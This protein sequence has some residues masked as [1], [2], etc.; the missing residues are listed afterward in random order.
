MKFTVQQKD[1]NRLLQVAGNGVPRKTTLPIL[2]NFLIEA[3]PGGIRVAATDLEISISTT[4]ET[5]VETPGTVAVN[6]RRLEEVVRELP[7]DAVE[8]SLEDGKFQMQCQR[9]R[10]QLFPMPAED[11]PTLSQERAAFSVKIPSKTFQRLVEMCTYSVS[12][13][14][15]RPALGGILVQVADKEIRFVATDGHRLAKA[16][17]AGAF[18]VEKKEPREAIVPPKALVPVAAWAV[19]SGSDVEMDISAS[20]AT[21]RVGPTTLTTRLLQGPFPNFEQVIPKENKKLLVVGREALLS[22]LRRVSKLSD[23]AS[24][25]VRVSLRKNRVHLSVSTADVGDARDDLE[26]RYGEDDLEIG[27]NAVYLLDILKSMDAD[28]V[29][30]AL[31]TPV[32]AGVVTP[33]DPK[34]DAQALCLIMPLRLQD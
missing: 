22:S 5:P 14:E 31:N 3:R 6:A 18:P 20:A 1:L 23:T 27:Y 29:Q 17:A 8:V 24:H 4:L 15:T 19:E 25:Q 12:T 33:V 13:D 34:S 7:K 2:S 32:T 11:F 21:F 26:A 10:V 28:N 30:F 16:Y 9:S